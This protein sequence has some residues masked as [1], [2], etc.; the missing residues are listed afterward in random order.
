MNRLPAV[1]R[2]T[3][4]LPDGTTLLADLP[5][6]AAENLRPSTTAT[7]GFGTLPV[8]LTAEGTE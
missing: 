8:L 7:V 2:V 5:S 4:T 6:V 3:A 1:T